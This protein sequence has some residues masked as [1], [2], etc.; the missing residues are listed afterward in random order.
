MT[1]AKRLIVLLAVPLLA[2]LGLGLFTRLQL[3]NIEERSRFVAESQV[4]SLALLGNLARSFAELRVSVRSHLLA[5]NQTQRTAARAAFDEDEQTVTRLLQQYGDALITGERD[6]RL[7][8]DF[9][10]LSRQWIVGAKQVMALANQGSG[11]EATALL[12]GAIAQVGL[13]L[14]KV[15]NQWIQHN[16]E[17][18]TAAGQAALAE[19]QSTRWQMLLAPHQRAI[20]PILRP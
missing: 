11:E 18:A 8:N 3:A 7:H 13:E 2:L 20:S 17:L 19:I 5:T 10:D 14:S 16:E 1:I 9:R 12:V 6:R 4:E 15:S